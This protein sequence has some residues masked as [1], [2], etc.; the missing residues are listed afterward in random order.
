MDSRGLPRAYNPSVQ[1]NTRG[2]QSHVPDLYSAIQAIL[3]C[4]SVMGVIPVLVW[5]QFVFLGQYSLYS[6]QYVP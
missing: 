2:N 4:C 3:Q 5:N 1:M 6:Y